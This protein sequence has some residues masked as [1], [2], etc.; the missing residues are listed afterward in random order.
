MHIKICRWFP[1]KKQN[2]MKFFCVEKPLDVFS[3]MQYNMST[4]T[5]DPTL[6][7]QPL[8]T[9]MR[10]QGTHMRPRKTYKNLKS[11]MWKKYVF[12]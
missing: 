2:V 3:R 1:T 5:T 12:Y 8:G 10:P 11:L 6:R 4:L 7:V 9:H